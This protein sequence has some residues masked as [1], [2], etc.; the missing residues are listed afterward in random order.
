MASS[1]YSVRSSFKKLGLSG[2]KNAVDAV[3]SESPCDLSASAR[4]LPLFTENEELLR[5]I[6]TGVCSDRPRL[7][8][9]WTSGNSQ[10]PRNNTWPF[11][12]S[13]AQWS[14]WRGL[15]ARQAALLAYELLG[16]S[17]S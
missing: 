3:S 2:G 17:F 7:S 12:T 16:R 6:P 1:G 10:G 9:D 11:L 14:G 13:K 5:S 4:F 15:A 8:S